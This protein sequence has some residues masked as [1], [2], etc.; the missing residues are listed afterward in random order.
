VTSRFPGKGSTVMLQSLWVASKYRTAA[1]GTGSPLFPHIVG[2]PASVQALAQAN[3][4][5][6]AR[7]RPFASW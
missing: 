2:S 4:N 5:A 6:V 1:G 3:G 7:H